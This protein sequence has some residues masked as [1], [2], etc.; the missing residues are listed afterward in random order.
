NTERSPAMT[1]AEA[2][3]SHA[4]ANRVSVSTSGTMRNRL[5]GVWGDAVFCSVGSKSRSA[6]CSFCGEDSGGVGVGFGMVKAP[7]MNESCAVYSSRFH[8]RPLIGSDVQTLGSNATAHKPAD[9][10]EVVGK[11]ARQDQCGF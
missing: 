11:G 2:S 3:D 4:L 10:G 6:A 5:L 8:A 7:A 1:L 9:S